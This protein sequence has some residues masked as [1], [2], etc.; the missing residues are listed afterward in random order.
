MRGDRQ[1]KLDK[2]KIS[3]NG[4]FRVGFDKYSGNYLMETDDT[5]GNN[6]YF[7]ITEEQYKWFDTEP[8]K[9][10]LLYNECVK[11]NNQ[12]DIFYFSNWERENSNEQ[13]TLMWK[14]MY[15]DMLI[16]K[17]IVEVHKKIGIPNKVLNDGRIEIFKMS[18]NL[19]IQ[20]VYRD[21]VCIDVL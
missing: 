18:S 17:N 14:Y 13:N 1:L 5:F 15:I 11:R 9:L 12:S 21:A 19:Q 20:V 3:P 16:G 4:Y 7:I 10:E 8:D 6:R 2:E